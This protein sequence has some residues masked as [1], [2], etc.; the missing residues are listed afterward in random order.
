MPEP[1]GHGVAGCQRDVGH[2]WFLNMDQAL[3]RA[4]GRKV[5]SAV[6]S[7]D[8]SLPAGRPPAL[9]L[10]YSVLTAKPVHS[11]TGGP[12]MPTL[13][14]PSF[15]SAMLVARGTNFGLPSS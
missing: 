4:T 15:I 14:Q 6:Q 9:R 7:A 11:G 3:K 5:A 10:V 1:I 12:L 2:V 13:I 8:G